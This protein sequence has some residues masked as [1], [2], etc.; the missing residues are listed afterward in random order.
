MFDSI[1][2][3]EHL[4]RSLT[5]EDL[6][7]PADYEAMSKLEGQTE[8]GEYRGSV[9]FDLYVRIVHRP[10]RQKPGQWVY[11]VNLDQEFENLYND[12]MYWRAEYV[13]FFNGLPVLAL[14]PGKIM[15]PLLQTVELI[16]FKVQAVQKI[17]QKFLSILEQK[18]CL[19]QFL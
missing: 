15:Q 1:S 8:E 12:D 5:A 18:P 4:K 19:C 13:K 9:L 3:L 7:T 16:R 10:H 6:F 14:E 2:K 17:P 11:L